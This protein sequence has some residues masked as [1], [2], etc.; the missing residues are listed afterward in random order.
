MSTN[1]ASGLCVSNQASPTTTAPLHLT[2]S[3]ALTTS[4]Q[5]AGL[6]MS[7]NVNMEQDLSHWSSGSLT[8]DSSTVPL[9]A[10]E[11]VPTFTTLLN[12]TMSTLFGKHVT[13]SSSLSHSSHSNTPG[14]LSNNISSHSKA[15][16]PASIPFL[17]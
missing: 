10:S 3:K 12:A 6:F 16:L 7:N 15:L 11:L 2:T 9:Q 17:H 4:T 5:Q 13:T 8:W 14:S 1:P